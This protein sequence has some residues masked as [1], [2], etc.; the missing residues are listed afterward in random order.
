MG[1]VVAAIA[2]TDY[3]NFS[4]LFPNIVASANATSSL[5]GFTGGL[6]ATASSTIGSGTQVGGLTI[7]GGATTTGNAYFGGNVGVGSST[8]FAAF[9][10]QANNG[11]TYPG[12][13]LFNIS[14]STLSG[15]ANVNLFSISNSGNVLVG[16]NFGSTTSQLFVGV[17][18]TTISMA[19]T[20]SVGL[21]NPRGIYVQGRYAYVTNL[22]GNSLVIFDVSNSNAPVR[23]GTQTTGISGPRGVYVSGRYAYVANN[24]NG[25]IAIVDVSNPATPQLVSTIAGG[26]SGPFGVYIQG[27]Y[28]QQRLARYL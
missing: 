21:N 16:Q 25:T 7:S 13:L 23:V 3:A 27:R 4:Y 24:S 11:S 8:P 10:I 1:Q 2:G 17:G 15:T 6:F 9:A 19:S 26:L 28:A 5:V 22:T 18:T 20:T 14:S 12:N